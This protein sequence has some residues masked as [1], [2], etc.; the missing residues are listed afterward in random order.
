[1]NRTVGKFRQERSL[2]SIT[3]VGGDQ[4]R[5]VIVSS[6]NAMILQRGNRESLLG[7]GVVENNNH[8]GWRRN[9]TGMPRLGRG[10]ERL[11]N[12]KEQSWDTYKRGNYL[13]EPTD[14]HIYTRMN[15]PRNVCFDQ[16]GRQYRVPMIIFV[17][18]ALGNLK[19]RDHIRVTYGSNQAWKIL[20]HTLV[21][22]VFMLGTTNDPVLQSKINAEASIYGDI[23]QEDFIDSYLNLTRKTVMGFKWVTEHC[24]HGKFAMKIDDDT[25]LNKARIL[26][27]ILQAPSRGVVIGNVNLDMPV[28]RSRY[29]E[30][31]KYR[32][33]KNFYPAS[34]YPPYLSGPAFIMSTDLVEATFRAALTT[35]LFP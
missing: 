3:A 31:G 23:V 19:R 27:F 20:N 13:L 6:A 8:A 33:S 32:I 35:P 1:M 12:E 2:R 10:E 25:M 28:V 21:R 29:G 4:G 30:W 5:F 15:T 26:E 34:K 7:D 17:T 11:D 18:S 14:P 22:T 16:Q 24:R 9:M